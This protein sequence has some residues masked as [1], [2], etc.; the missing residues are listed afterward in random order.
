ML[1]ISGFGVGVGVDG[2]VVVVVVV[3]VLNTEKSIA[4]LGSRR[5]ET[6]F[7]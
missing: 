6:S 4:N 2:V 3:H 5:L 1:H 7:M